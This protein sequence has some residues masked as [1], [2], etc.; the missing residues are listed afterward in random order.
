[1]KINDLVTHKEK[2]ATVIK[3]YGEVAKIQ[4]A[5][6]GCILYVKIEDLTVASLAKDEGRNQSKL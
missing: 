5:G 4:M 2:A 6:T 1:M 3:V